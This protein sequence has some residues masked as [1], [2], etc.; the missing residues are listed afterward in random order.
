[1]CGRFALSIP[2]EVIAELLRIGAFP[3]ISPRF[4]IAPAQQVLAARNGDAGREFTTFTWGLVPAWSKDPSAAPKMIN[5]RAETMFEKPAYRDPAA[6]QRCIIPADG[7]Y[8][9]DLRPEMNKHPWFIRRADHQPMLFA[10]LYDTWH[11][12]H[13]ILA[14]CTVVTTAAG[15]PIA[16][17]HHRMP[18]ILESGSVDEWLDPA[19][20]TRADLGHLLHAAPPNLIDAH[21]V[22]RRVNK[23]DNDTPVLVERVDPEPP[24]QPSLFG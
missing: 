19:R 5:A 4:N 1:M 16:D 7:F 3:L 15:P 21:P 2:I 23:V 17:I 8:E 12:P 18:V 22:S 10:G 11:G 6:A 24:E 14:T 20:R 9:W 13:G